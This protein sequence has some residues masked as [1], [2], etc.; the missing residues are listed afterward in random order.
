MTDV[1]RERY[2]IGTFVRTPVPL[3]PADRDALISEIAWLPAEVRALVHGLSDQDL[4]TAYRSGGWTIRQ[5]VHHLP[6]SHINAYVRMKLALTEDAPVVKVYMED[7]WAALPEARSGPVA[8][9]LDLLDA[10][11][12]R[13]VAL[14]RALPASDFARLYMH[15]ELGA[16]PLDVGLGLYAWHGKHH[17]AHIRAALDRTSA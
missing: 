8:M 6:D 2:P 11:H 14:L 15:P 13:W 10:L 1:D 7:R 9:S 4:D 5:L 16:V 12:R 3:D 17:C